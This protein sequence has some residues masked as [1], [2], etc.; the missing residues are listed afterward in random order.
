MPI[1]MSTFCARRVNGA[2]EN[3]CRVF[4]R[5]FLNVKGN[6]RICYEGPMGARAI[7]NSYRGAPYDQVT[8]ILELRH[9]IAVCR[10][11]NVA[12]E[13]QRP[14]VCEAR[15]VIPKLGLPFPNPRSSLPVGRNS[16]GLTASADRV[17]SQNRHF[18]PN[19]RS[20]LPEGTIDSPAHCRKGPVLR[21]R[22]S[23]M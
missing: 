11:T 19:D 16:S 22:H 6:S 9:S 13:P 7:G 1:S 12:I 10:E 21:S 20:P 3:K 8:G 15:R 14:D 18:A 17:L 4:L 5:G 2:N 23:C